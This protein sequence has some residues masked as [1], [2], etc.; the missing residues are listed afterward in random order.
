MKPSDT[1]QHPSANVQPRVFRA[2]LQ[3]QAQLPML[4]AAAVMPSKNEI[5]IL[6]LKERDADR[7]LEE[8]WSGKIEEMQLTTALLQD[9]LQQQQQLVLESQSRAQTLD[10]VLQQR[11]FEYEQLLQQS[12]DEMARLKLDHE[13]QL[14]QASQ[15]F[16]QQVQATQRSLQMKTESDLA[17]QAEAARLETLRQQLEEYRQQL[18]EEHAQLQAHRSAIQV[19]EATAEIALSTVANQQ[20]NMHVQNSQLNAD[21]NAEKLLWEKQQ[22]IAFCND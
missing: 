19:Q 5:K 11:T 14:Q 7:S 15:A 20:A 18:E 21:R 6:H 22:V 2:F 17:I 3:A 10:E 8:Y 9:E 12:A 16:A 4:K 1:M 13:S